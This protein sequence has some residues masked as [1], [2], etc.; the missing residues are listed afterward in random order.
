[1]TG[2]G[3]VRGRLAQV[4]VALVVVGLVA[5][6]S[7]AAAPTSKTSAARA[8]GRPSKQQ[9]PKQQPPKQQPPPQQPPQQPP[10][11]QRLLYW[12]AWIGSQLTGNE[13]P[14][15]TGAITAFEHEVGK[16][17]SL[18]NF[19][20]PWENCYST[21][22]TT[23]NFD[24]TAMN[25]IRAA[26]AIPF[27]SWGSDSLPLSANEPNFSLSNI[28]AGNWD[29]YIT[30]WATAAKNWG[31]PF[32]LRFDWE[33]NA[34]WFPW[35]VGAN[36]NSSA[37]YV[38]AWRHV[39]DIFTSVG[40]TNVTWVWCPNIDPSNQYAPLASVYPGSSYVDWAGLDGYNWGGPW[41][42]FNQLFQS[43]YNTIATSVAP[44]KPIVIGETAS[45]EK[46]GSK[47]AWI[48]DL[49]GTELPNAYPQV[50]AFLW[51]EK[52]DSGMDWPVETSASSTA[53]FSAGI[54]SSIYATNQF[55]SLAGGTIS[56]LS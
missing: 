23:Y 45:T 39:H 37:Q 2:G 52:Y 6:A 8:A 5:S 33:M 29:S 56:P 55:G 21:P 40:A 30:S 42:S 38:Q 11:T 19:S 14:W 36:G 1:M 17:L 54:S 3:F 4:L 31:H 35:G 16:N 50:K 32:F 27:F 13:A 18:V 9:P 24:T 22:C 15:D 49:L 28:I 51:F 43:T 25:N 7:A 34:S 44:G 53:A 20:S 47:A 26:G 48:T 46:G 41:M 10:Q 12:G